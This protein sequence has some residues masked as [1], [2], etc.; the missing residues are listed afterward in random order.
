ML[1]S[2]IMLFQRKKMNGRKL[3]TCAAAFFLLFNAAAQAQSSTSSV[4][5]SPLA[6]VNIQPD[7]VAVTGISSGAFMATQLQLAYP[8]IFPFAAML[9]GGPYD[10]ALVQRDMAKCLYPSF[11]TDKDL[12]AAVNRAKKKSY[13]RLLGDFSHLDHGIVYV[14]YG[15]A[16]KVVGTQIAGSITKFYQRLKSLSNGKLDGLQISEDGSRNFGHTFPTYLTP[17]PI[18]SPHEDDDCVESIPPY[19]GHCGFDAAKNI[20]QHLYPQVTTGTEPTNTSG[21]LIRLSADSFGATAATFAGK[22][23]YV[24]KPA[25]CSNGTPCGLLVVLHG[26]NQNDEAIGQTFVQNVG[27]NRW[28]EDYRLIVV[29]PQTKT[30][31]E[32]FGGCWDWWGYTGHHFDTRNAPQISWLARIAR[33]LSSQPHADQAA[34]R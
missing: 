24:Y 17:L 3:F 32:N 2:F 34:N 20:L 27:F 15:T 13:Y 16:D 10:C 30:V 12:S 29:Y 33:E 5:K 9:A 28:A 23:V 4:V 8:K 31:K 22:W 6:D 21:A 14:L 19:L 7:R 25:A 1:V 11:I 26:C 18:A